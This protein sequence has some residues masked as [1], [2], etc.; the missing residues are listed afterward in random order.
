MTHLKSLALILL[1][2][3]VL[4]PVSSLLAQTAVPGKRCD[5]V[6]S[7]KA[8]RAA[9]TRVLA[10]HQAALVADQRALASA[11]PGSREAL[12]L[13]AKIAEDLRD[14]AQNRAAIA[15]MTNAISIACR[16]LAARKVRCPDCATAAAN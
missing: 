12:T 16:D 9:L 10:G 13:K 7:L 5:D 3:L 4:G 6:V 14:I 2:G 8:D 1:L 15:R 11:R